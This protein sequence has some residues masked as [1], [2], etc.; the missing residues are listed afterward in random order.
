MIRLS[1]FTAAGVR[2]PPSAVGFVRLSASSRLPSLVPLHLVG[3]RVDRRGRTP[4]RGPSRLEPAPFVPLC[5]TQEQAPCHGARWSEGLRGPAGATGEP[6]ELSGTAFR[7]TASDVRVS[8]LPSALGGTLRPLRCRRPAGRP[9]RARPWPIASGA[10]HSS[11]GPVYGKSSSACVPARKKRRS[12][13]AEG[14]EQDRERG[15]SGGGP[16]AAALDPVWP[17][18]GFYIGGDVRDRLPGRRAQRL[19]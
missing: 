17:P 15:G 19:L 5:R 10:G 11:P 14:R 7:S 13:S 4:E 16:R 18:P 8:T 1:P 9:G 3:C 6:G 2:R 12:G